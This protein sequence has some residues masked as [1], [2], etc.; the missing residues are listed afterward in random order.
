M[1]F[2]SKVFIFPYLSFFFFFLNGKAQR[3]A[4]I[5]MNRMLLLYML[6]G[7][8]A[9]ASTVSIPPYYANLTWEPARTLSM[10]HSLT[11]ET[12]TGTFV[13]MLNDTY[14]NVRQF[15]R[16]PYAKVSDCCGIRRLL[17]CG[18]KD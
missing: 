11:V 3:P 7:G 6:L 2:D 17:P 8:L 9:V 14:P 15:L 16:I 18:F 10:W 4:L 13:G 1:R 5:T 12:E